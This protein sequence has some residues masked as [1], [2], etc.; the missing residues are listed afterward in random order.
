MTKR[1]KTVRKLLQIRWAIQN[2]QHLNGISRG[3]RIN[4]V[5]ERKEFKKIS[6]TSSLCKFLWP[7]PSPQVYAEVESSAAWVS[8]LR[9]AEM[10][11]TASA[12]TSSTGLLTASWRARLAS[13]H[14]A[15][16]V[17]SLISSGCL[18]ND[19]WGKSEWTRIIDPT[20]KILHFFFLQSG[21]YRPD[22][23]LFCSPSQDLSKEQQALLVQLCVVHPQTSL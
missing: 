12:A 17:N 20:K 23:P 11:F 22:A 16:L 13:L 21:S 9:K 4:R 3:N 8:H 1:W 18:R 15:E 7:W 10:A 5:L 14:M 19:K 2:V 6:L